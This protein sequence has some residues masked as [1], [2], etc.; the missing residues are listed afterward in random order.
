MQWPVPPPDRQIA[1]ALGADIGVYCEYEDTFGDFDLNHLVT[2]RVTQLLNGTTSADGVCGQ[3]LT[4]VINDLPKSGYWEGNA[5]K[6]R[7]WLA[8]F[9][10]CC[11]ADTITLHIHGAGHTSNEVT[12][13]VAAGEGCNV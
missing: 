7:L 9:G 4:S 6:G 13:R 10:G 3:R 11:P 2:Y 8:V 5:H 1:A 12:V